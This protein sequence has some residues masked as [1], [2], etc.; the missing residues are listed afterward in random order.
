V[1]RILSIVLVL[2][3]MMSFATFATE[4]TVTEA[5]VVKVEVSNPY[6]TI[7]GFK[8][9]FEKPIIKKNSEIMIAY[10]DVIN[11]SLY[12]NYDPASKTVFAYTNDDIFEFKV[13]QS[14]TKIS[15]K[16][17][18]SWVN[19]EAPFAQ[20]DTIYVPMMKILEHADAIVTYDEFGNLFVEL[21]KE[22]KVTTFDSGSVYDGNYS[23]GGVSKQGYGKYTWS[24]GESYEG[25]W[26]DDERSGYGKF[27]WNSGNYYLGYF[28]NGHRDGYGKIYNKYGEVIE[29]GYYIKGVLQAQVVQPQL[30]QPQ[31][32]TPVESTGELNE[33][34]EQIPSV[35]Y[36]DRWHN[37][38][39]YVEDT[40]IIFGRI[41]EYDFNGEATLIMIDE[42]DYNYTL[43]YGQ[44]VDSFEV[45][46]M[47]LMLGQYGGLYDMEDE[48]YGIV[49]T[50]LLDEYT[51]YKGE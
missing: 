41:V 16:G 50:I 35:P 33:G 34:A 48:V 14:K 49:E 22:R 15:I 36:I 24:D 47:V 40:I 39:D 17:S 13:G 37:P 2:V 6:I 46:D 42:G 45:G 7:D 3:T 9:R 23:F 26:F 21:P 8:V 44:Y 25:N 31:V 20:N 29:E 5:P 32:N 12:A 1:K 18:G 11:I 10:E 43:A 27:T 19:V 4:T 30:V 38:E 51:V 28:Y